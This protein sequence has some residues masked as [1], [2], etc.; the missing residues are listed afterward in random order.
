MVEFVLLLFGESYTVLH[1]QLLYQVQRVQFLHL[2]DDY[3]LFHAE[4]YA[5]M[6]KTV[7]FADILFTIKA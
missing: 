6:L 7:F 2:L 5:M 1:E 4:F 3:M